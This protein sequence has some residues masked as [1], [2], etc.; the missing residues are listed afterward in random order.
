MFRAS[1]PLELFLDLIFVV[2]VSLSSAEF[3]HLQSAGHLVS[4]GISYLMVFFG[5][6]WAWVNFTWFAS[7]FDVDDWLYRLLTL[8]QMAGVLILAVGS[9]PAMT[10]ADF[11]LMIAGY[12]VMRLALIAQWLRASRSHPSMRRTALRYAAG[13]GVVQVLWV[14]FVFVP[15]GWFMPV[16]LVLVGCELAVPLWAETVRRTPWHP[17]H[18]VDRYG[19]FTLI[20]LGESVLAS[21]TAVSVAAGDGRHLGQ[22]VLIGFCGLVLAAGMWWLYFA[23]EV[24]ERLDDL[25]RAAVFGYGH[26]VVFASAGAFSTGIG[27]LLDAQVGATRLSPHLAA[28]TLTIPVAVFVVSVWALILRHH[29]SG[30][31]RVLV[32]VLGVLLGACALLPGAIVAAAFVMVGL[33]FVVEWHRV[34]AR[35]T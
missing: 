23:T 34:T 5:I 12:V 6:W 13:V 7:A 11:R 26:F 28:S 27:V 16:W 18:I 31:R 9:G 29:L 2:A 14:L 32:P 24:S 10:A 8:A 35:A 15:P 3:H 1:S 20:V 4:G 33:V 21:T 22:L 19:S 30:W 25:P 17:G